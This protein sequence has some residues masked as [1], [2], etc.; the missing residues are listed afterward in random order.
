M[1]STL[2][3]AN[4]RQRR[5]VLVRLDALQAQNARSYTDEQQRAAAEALGRPDWL[6]EMQESLPLEG[7]A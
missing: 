6:P 7:A 1:R 4:E 5:A 2:A 3:D